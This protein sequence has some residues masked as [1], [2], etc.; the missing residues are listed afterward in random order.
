MGNGE[1]E[2]EKKIKRNFEKIR[3]GGKRGLIHPI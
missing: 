2:I 3:K 1:M